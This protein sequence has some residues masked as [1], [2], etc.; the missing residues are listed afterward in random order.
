MAASSWTPPCRT[1]RRWAGAPGRL[2][3]PGSPRIN[4]RECR[5]RRVMLFRTMRRAR[6]LERRAQL[7]NLRSSRMFNTSCGPGMS[8]G[9]AADVIILLRAEPSV[10]RC[11][12]QKYLLRLSPSAMKVLAFG[13][14][15]PD[16]S[17]IASLRL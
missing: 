12:G 9:M 4:T 15:A 17:D 6:S 13:Q 8:V 10:A 11:A 5:M 1:E 2:H 14:Y 3:K 16:A 7:Y